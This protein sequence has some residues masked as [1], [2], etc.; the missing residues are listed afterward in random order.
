MEALIQEVDGKVIENNGP[1]TTLKQKL[2]Q[3]LGLMDAVV[4]EMQKDA[5]RERAAGLE[6]NAAHQTEHQGQ[7]DYCDEHG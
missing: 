1:W 3:V 2:Q 4:I 6:R 5:D 7:Q